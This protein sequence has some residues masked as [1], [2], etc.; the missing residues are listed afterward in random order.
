[1]KV[2]G[3]RKISHFIN[4]I[5]WSGRRREREGNEFRVARRLAILASIFHRLQVLAACSGGKP[6]G[7]H[8]QLQSES[9]D[10]LR[11]SHNGP[12]QPR[13][14]K[15]IMYSSER[16]TM[17]A[18]PHTRETRNNYFV[19]MNHPGRT[20][21]NASRDGCKN[22]SDEKNILIMRTRQFLISFC[23]LLRPCFDLALRRR[24]ARAP[25]RFISSLNYPFGKCDKKKKNKE[26]KNG[27]RALERSFANDSKWIRRTLIPRQTISSPS[28]LSSLRVLCVVAT[29]SLHKIR[30]LFIWSIWC[31]L[32]VRLVNRMCFVREQF[33]NK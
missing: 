29:L 11:K 15:T 5:K 27:H 25:N 24:R 3:V 30:T 16:P 17:T 6:F 7:P 14:N 20:V 26:L 33:S 13:E 23:P 8:R 31:A 2:V 22:D 4:E 18:S 12:S 19:P 10:C 32:S 1:M 28:F 21:H 9:A